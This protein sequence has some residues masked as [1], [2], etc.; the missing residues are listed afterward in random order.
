[1]T[2]VVNLYFGNAITNELSAPN[3]AQVINDAVRTGVVQS[4]QGQTQ[5]RQVLQNL[6]TA[7]N[8]QVSPGDWFKSGYMG[9]FAQGQTPATW[10]LAI[11]A[12]SSGNPRIDRV[13]A[14]VDTNAW[15][16]SLLVLTGTP[17]GS[18][19]APTINAVG[20][21]LQI[22]LCQV[23]V[24]NGATAIVNANI[25]DER[26][27][28]AVCGY[29][30]PVP[31]ELTHLAGGGDPLQLLDY[32]EGSPF[33]PGSN[34]TDTGLTFLTSSTT[35][36]V[37]TGKTLYLT[38]VYTIGGAGLVITAPSQSA[39]TM[40]HNATAGTAA[41][42]MLPH[43]ICLAAGSV[44]A[45]SVATASSAGIR[46]FL[47]PATGKLASVV[48]VAPT[49][50]GTAYTVA[51]NTWFVLSHIYVTS[52]N[53]A[54][55]LVGGTLNAAAFPDFSTTLTTGASMSGS[56]TIDATTVRFLC[57]LPRPVLFPPGTALY[58]S[59]ALAFA[60]YTWS[61]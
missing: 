19:V 29:A 58:S 26:G 6:G 55:L 43:P 36:T 30:A 59:G 37:P 10:V 15:T 2:A 31:H 50:L 22:A 11:S 35:Y 40:F 16:A 38:Q 46:G 20:T 39:T 4:S 23:A 1:M 51:P 21:Q 45:S 12:N 5:P 14:Q 32:P 41:L 3:I 13:V 18:P 34:V 17:A 56:M 8:V 57:A 28:T 52:G 48:E 27:A 9:S 60:G 33:A 7:M 24:A 25:T 42:A 49:T 47:V 61:Q 44:L 53:T 54:T